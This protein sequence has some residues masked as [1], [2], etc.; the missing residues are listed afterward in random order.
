MRVVSTSTA[1]PRA[2]L[3]VPWSDASTTGVQ[4]IFIRATTRRRDDGTMKYEPQ[5][6]N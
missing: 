6:M 2:M 4:I 1:R 5:T 3:R